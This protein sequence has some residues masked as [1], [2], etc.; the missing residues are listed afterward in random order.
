MKPITILPSKI[1]QEIILGTILGDGS[2]EFNGNIGTRLQI[3][4]RAAHKDYVFWLYEKLKNLCNSGP[5]QRRDNHQWYFSTKALKELT[6]LYRIFYKER[7]IIPKDI[8]DRLTSS[9]SLA[10]WYM[11]DGYLDF[12]PK[13]HYAF[14]LSTDGFS[15]KEV[16]ILSKAI[17]KNFGIENSVC[18]PLCRGKNILKFISELE[19]EI[20]FFF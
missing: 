12:R 17:E 2:L 5:K 11:D 3:K 6:S 18:N 9:I 4:Q 1:Q 15:M 19:E 13:D 10:V 7:K 16:Q 14:I 8:L 20:N